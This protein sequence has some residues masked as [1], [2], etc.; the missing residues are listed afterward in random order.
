MGGIYDENLTTKAVTL[1]VH[2][3]EKGVNVNLLNLS[4][5]MSTEETGSD[6]VYDVKFDEQFWVDQQC[7]AKLDTVSKTP[8]IRLRLKTSYTLDTF[9]TE[10]NK[11]QLL[12]RLEIRV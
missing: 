3:V 12:K 8:V 9:M 7:T 6:Y 5:E 11:I 2:R 10:W 4:T 1:S